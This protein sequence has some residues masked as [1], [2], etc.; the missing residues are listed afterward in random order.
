MENV[1]YILDLINS[2]KQIICDCGYEFTNIAED[3]YKYSMSEVMWM[4]RYEY[5]HIICPGCHKKIFNIKN[6][7]LYIRKQKI[8][9]I[10]RKISK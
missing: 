3:Q 8:E 10:C 5:K 4:D 1:D 9:A 6:V 7:K 2:L